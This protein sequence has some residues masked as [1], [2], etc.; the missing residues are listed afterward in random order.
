MS[1]H[2]TTFRGEPAASTGI[3]WDDMASLHRSDDG[4]GVLHRLKAVRHG[5]LVE[6]VRFVTTLPEDERERYVIEKM[7]DRRFGP[8]E[9]AALARRP[10]FP[11]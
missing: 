9:I 4:G 7:G 10:D 6:L 11:N 1:D 8:G 2:P 5:T 3:G